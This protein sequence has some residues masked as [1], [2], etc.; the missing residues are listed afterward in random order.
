[1]VVVLELQLLPLPLHLPV[2]FV[3]QPLT[4][5]YRESTPALCPMR[6]RC[7][8]VAACPTCSAGPAP[9]PLS[10]GFRVDPACSLKS[11]LDEHAAS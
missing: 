2:A 6:G 8:L 9:K 1:M 4:I 3:Q 11:G 10:H 7:R 5:H